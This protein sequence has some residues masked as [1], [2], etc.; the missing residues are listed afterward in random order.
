MKK[1]LYVDDLLIYV[2]GS[3]LPGLERRLQSAINAANAW[4]GEN[5]LKF[6]P[7]KSVAIHFHRKRAHQTPLNL[8]LGDIEI[9]NVDS[10]KYL[11]MVLDSKL[12][13]KQ[14]IK[15]IKTNCVKRLDLLKHLS[16]TDWGAHRTIMLRLYR[17]IIRSKLDYG[18][19][20]VSY[21]HLT[22]P[23]KRIV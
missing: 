18:C 17:S 12:S 11:G 4:A 21:T 23:T 8:R 13:W 7:T 1:S 9:P 2:S 3:Y 5:G 6:S 20:P 22:L 16:N 14:H 10:I 15:S 19:F